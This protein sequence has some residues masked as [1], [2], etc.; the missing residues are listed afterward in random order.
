MVGGVLFEL[1]HR[2]AATLVSCL[3]SSS[4]GRSS[5]VD[6]RPSVRAFGLLAPLAVVVQGVLAA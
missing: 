5:S 1:G 3:T 4:R 6:P 2:M